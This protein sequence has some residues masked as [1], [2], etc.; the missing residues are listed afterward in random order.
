[1]HCHPERESHRNRSFQLT[2]VTSNIGLNL[3][4]LNQDSSESQ[5]MFKSWA[6]SRP[7]ADVCS[8]SSYENIDRNGTD[9]PKHSLDRPIL[10]RY[11]P[12]ETSAQYSCRQALRSG[13]DRVHRFCFSCLDI[14][15]LG[16][17]RPQFT[18]NDF[19]VQSYYP[20][21]AGHV[22]QEAPLLFR[23]PV[24][25]C[26][27]EGHSFPLMNSFTWQEDFDVLL[28]P[29]AAI[30]VSVQLAVFHR[31][32]SEMLH[33]HLHLVSFDGAERLSHS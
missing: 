10:S 16:L 32:E 3:S 20:W 21:S 13:E 27:N 31:S 18:F 5:P 25:G 30:H 24:E 33:P 12:I 2:T 15:W 4:R 29:V 8:L 17:L 6:P 7:P 11:M 19:P 9:S 22:Y 1:M 26:E 23:N 28:R 14:V